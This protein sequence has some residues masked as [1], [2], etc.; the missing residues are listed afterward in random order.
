MLLVQKR[1]ARPTEAPRGRQRLASPRH[2]ERSE[3]SKLAADQ[4]P[5]ESSRP[6]LPHPITLSAA[7]LAPDQN[8]TESP[9]PH[10]HP[11]ILSE[12]KNLNSRRTEVLRGWVRSPIGAKL[13]PATF[14]LIQ[15]HPPAGCA[16]CGRIEGRICHAERS[17]ASKL[18][19]NYTPAKPLT[20]RLTVM[21]SAPPSYSPARGGSPLLIPPLAGEIGQASGSMPAARSLA[22]RRSARACSASARARSASARSSPV[23]MTAPS[24]SHQRSQVSS[25]P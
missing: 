19:P 6:P 18:A 12:A 20:P 2:P 3:E 5:A 7:T 23:G 15:G 9:R 1:H 16:A 22:A 4:S 24:R 21:L 14:A 10:L 17:E 25:Q 11:V 8:P 13:S